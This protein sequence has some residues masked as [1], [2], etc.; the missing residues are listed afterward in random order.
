V[1]L[2]ER[3]SPWLTNRLIKNKNYRPN[4]I[5]L[6]A[7]IT[8][9]DNNKLKLVTGKHNKVTKQIIIIIKVFLVLTKHNVR[10]LWGEL[11]YNSTRSLTSVLEDEDS[12]TR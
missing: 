8:V 6:N 3:V 10:R 1:S 2:R 5:H 12:F 4:E 9:L 7:F 11:R